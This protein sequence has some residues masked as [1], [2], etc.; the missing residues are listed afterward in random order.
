MPQRKLITAHLSLIIN[1]NIL[2]IFKTLDKSLYKY[3]MFTSIKDYIMAGL[4]A[5]L[6]LFAGLGY[7][8]F[9]SSQNEI[10]TL[11][12]NQE[13]L[14]TAVDIQTGTINFLLKQNEVQSKSIIQLNR[15]QVNAEKEKEQLLNTL[16][17]HNL[18]TLAK[19][20]PNLVEDKMNS[21]TKKAFRDLENETAN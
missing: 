11:T 12:A 7:L 16:R 21:A 17:K 2:E 3:I 19:T 15:D 1:F 5:A 10:K 8:Y 4:G 20:K 9:R 13:K 18:E 6:L 14:K